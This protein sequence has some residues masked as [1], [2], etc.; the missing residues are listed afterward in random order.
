MKGGGG[1]PFPSRAAAA[2]LSRREC[3]GR[4]TEGRAAPHSPPARGPRVA[5]SAL[6]RR[7]ARARG[8]EEA[9]LPAPPPGRNGRCLPVPRPRF[10]RSHRHCHTAPLPASAR[11][12]RGE[13]P[14]RRT[15][16]AP[17]RYSWWSSPGGWVAPLG[18]GPAAGSHVGSPPPFMQGRAVCRRRGEVGGQV[19][20]SVPVPPVP[21]VERVLACD[22]SSPHKERNTWMLCG[23]GS[24]RAPA[25]AWAYFHLPAGKPAWAGRAARRPPPAH[26]PLLRL[27]RTPLPAARAPPPPL[28]QCRC[29]RRGNSP[30]IFPPNVFF[31]FFF[32]FSRI[33]EILL[34]LSS[35]WL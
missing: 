20:R 10:S 6:P 7:R 34:I 11:G 19:G 3:G 23:P 1:E 35:F 24:G 30:F 32:N 9:G 16:P 28:A 31:F 18:S 13:P 25:W 14:W 4:G 22:T 12:W 26:R 21:G 8:G 15:P 33:L 5:A 29:G 2:F 17:C 27:H